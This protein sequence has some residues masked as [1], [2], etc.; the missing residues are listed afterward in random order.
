MTNEEIKNLDF[1][2]ATLRLLIDNTAY[3]RTIIQTQ[4]EILNR[5][6]S[7]DGCNIALSTYKLQKE[8]EAFVNEYIKNNFPLWWDMKPPMKDF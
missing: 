8:N 3:L 4:M 5:L 2:K 6:S 7:K 1:Q